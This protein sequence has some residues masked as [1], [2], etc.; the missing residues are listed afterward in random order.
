M[1]DSKYTALRAAGY[2]GSIN[3]MER[4]YYLANGATSRQLNEAKMQWLIASGFTS[5]ALNDRLVSKFR[6]AGYTGSV[7]DME[8]AFWK[9]LV[10]SDLPQSLTWDLGG[11]SWVKSDANKT[12]TSTT[13][14]SAYVFSGLIGNSGKWITR[15][16]FTTA[17]NGAA[18][19]YITLSG[20]PG[21]AGP[22]SPGQVITGAGASVWA[23]SMTPNGT[24][25]T[26]G[27]GDVIDF[28]IDI[29]AGKCWL[30]KNGTL[31]Q[32][33]PVAGTSPSITFTPGNIYVGVG[34][35]N[36]SGGT[37][38]VTFSNTISD[39]PAGYSPK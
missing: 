13:A 31:M 8:S 23:A 4:D 37:V 3:E 20:Q 15:F 5:G 19:R 38:V 22:P 35:S 16:T 30:R 17:G 27:A 10:A 25:P 24:L 33:D 29:T 28:V 18:D 36:N 1:N 21:P 39:I 6:T 7:Q 32:G 12:V 34:R 11:A 2:T 14:T 26:F 9:S